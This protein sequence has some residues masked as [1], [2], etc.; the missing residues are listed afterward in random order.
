[1][2]CFLRGLVI[3]DPFHSP[4]ADATSFHGSGSRGIGRL[5]HRARAGEF[6]VFLFTCSTA[7]TMTRHV[8]ICLVLLVSIG[9]GCIGRGGGEEENGAT[10]SEKDVALREET[11]L[12][13]ADSMEHLYALGMGAHHM[14]AGLWVI[15]RDH[16]RSPEA[17]LRQDI[18][19][20]APFHWR[21]AY[22]IE[23]DSAAREVTV[24]VPAVGARTAAYN[25]D[26]GCTLLPAGT[27]DVYFDPVHLTSDLPPPG[28]QEW[29]TGGRNAHGTV[30][31]V[32]QSA[33][34]SVM[35]WAFDDGLQEPDQNTR[36]VVVVYRGKIIAE[37]YADGW[38]PQTPQV[39][40]SMGKSIA[41]ALTGIMV[42]RDHYDLDDPAPIEE[43]HGAG[44]PRSNIRIRDLM[45]MSSGLDFDNFGLDPEQSFRASNE[46]MRIYFDALNVG[47]HAINQPLRFEPGTT[48]RY[49]NSDPLSL[50]LTA[51][52]TVEEEGRS[53]LAFPQRALF[54]R[55]GMRNM[56]LETDPWGNF[57]VTGYDYGSTRDWARFGL[58]HLWDGVWEGER[59]LPEG[60]TDFVRTPAPGHS[61]EGYGGLFWLNRSGVLSRVPTD[62][63]FAAGYMG[64]RTL[65]VPSR[66]L[67]VVRQGP[68]AGACRPY[69]NRLVGG[70][71]EAIGRPVESDGSAGRR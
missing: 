37:R 66:D 40:W 29:P 48:W 35:T 65:I 67:V 7:I 31:G 64:Q 23:V 71:L 62:A 6:T 33:L 22:E 60:W 41:G 10:A 24:R 32:D 54:D 59:I 44:D 52:R 53:W 63:C 3:L 49:R 46:Y 26:Q 69:F 18:A 58:L 19:P 43:W 5:G 56:V 47:L 39:S 12:A 1:M 25:G 42:E 55:I 61:S 2:L 21:E 17:V 15:G 38:G 27:R 50:M 45:Q 68:S 36:G 16:Q 51:R 11:N 34:D 8:A 4:R 9:A 57:I 70:I 20:F 13:L 14:C 28:E 30:E